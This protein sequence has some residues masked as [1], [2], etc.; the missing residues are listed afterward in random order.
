VSFSNAPGGLVVQGGNR[1]VGFELCDAK[2]HCRFVDA[3]VQEDRVLLDATAVP[4]PAAVRYGWANSPICNLY[5]R[6]DL[7]AVPFEVPVR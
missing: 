1:P 7:P 3:T 4:D 2:R 6:T 5:N